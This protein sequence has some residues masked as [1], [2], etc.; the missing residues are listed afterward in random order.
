MKDT[1]A[2]YR[3]ILY[4]PYLDAFYNLPESVKSMI[5]PRKPLFRFFRMAGYTFLRLIG[6]LFETVEHPE[7]L[8]GK[9]WLYVVSQNNYDSLKFIADTLPET[10][11][12]AGQNKDIGKYHN[13]V[14]RI[15]LRRKIL[16]YYKFPYLLFQFL[17]RRP[18]ITLRFVDVLYDAVGFYEVYHQKLQQF[19]PA[20]IVFAND[21]NPDARAMLL[22]AKALGIKTAY[23]QHASVSTTFPPLQF[24]LSLLEGQDSLD[25]YIECGPI[26]GEVKLI[27]MP[28]ADAFVSARNRN[29]TIRTIGIGASLLDLIEELEKL[30]RK[31]SNCLPE[32]R[33]IV[34]PHPRD[35]RDFTYLQS[36]APTVSI[37]DSSKEPTFEYLQHLDVM[38]SS[39]SSVHLEA[40]LMNVWSIYYNF[41]SIEPLHD[42]Y[43]YVAQGLV[44]AISTP[45]KLCDMLTAR[46][47]DKPDVFLRARYYNAT[48]GTPYDGK[49]SE[50]ALQHIA[51]FTSQ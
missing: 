16:Y 47:Q 38:I 46:L 42:V 48:V 17:K 23:V 28:K 10:V 26:T 11:L 2:L 27:G 5:S 43:G 30:T 20:A 4:R 34:R 44:E 15:S 14:E 21:H 40:V 9:V 36:I 31:L 51:N 6:N 32:V 13:V 35:K 45:E 19:K 3:N 25:K 1:L 8:K 33:I 7:K 49:S 39:N 37:S 24:D 29:R 41:N 50:L 12:V 22:A 18:E